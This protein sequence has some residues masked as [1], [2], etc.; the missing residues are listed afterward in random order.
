MNTSLKL[1]TLGVLAY[2][3]M[4]TQKAGAQGLPPA[5]GLP[6]SGSILQSNPIISAPTDP[7]TE[8]A[9]PKIDGTRPAATSG[10]ADTADEERV[11]V[12]RIVVDG[13]PP[14]LETAIKAI[15]VP[16]QD[17]Q[18][19]LNDLRA[20]A[21]QVTQVLLD[22]GESLSYAYVPQQD[23]VDDVVRLAILRGHVESI[24]L[25]HNNSLVRD[26]VV[27][28]FLK[29]GLTQSGEL[30]VAQGQLDI[31]S[32]LPGIGGITPVLAAGDTPGG[33]KLT[34]NVDPTRRFE[35]AMVFDNA[36]S[37]S[38]GRNRVGA[39]AT[40]NSPL[41]IGDRL[42]VV[43]YGAPDFL[44][45]NHDSDGGFT[46]IGRASYDLPVNAR[47]ARAGFSF[48]R[49]N[50]NYGGGLRYGDGTPI[51][52]GLATVY[53]LYGSSPLLRTESSTLD[54]N[55]NLDYKRMSDWL[56]DLTNNRS[57]PVLGLQLNGTKRG[58]VFGLPNA[59]QYSAGASFGHL[60]RDAVL[61]D[62][63]TEGNFVKTTQSAR[64]T[65]G[66]VRG[67]YLDVTFDAQQS[68]RNLD[69]SEKMVLGGPGAVRAYSNDAASADSGYVA[70]TTLNVAVPKVN[71]VTLQA[72]YDRAQGA[73]SKFGGSKQNINISGAGV[74]VN[75]DVGK[76]VSANLSYAMRIG[77]DR[78][79]GSQ[80]KSMVW[81]SSVVRF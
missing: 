57:A 71:G 37:T 70:T 38:T 60:S 48:T 54:I 69:G 42:Q 22:N 50:Y 12:A 32:D 55:A 25:G 77:N 43:A 27:N 52:V 19:S 76:H 3:A 61:G 58:S 81:A 46:V 28:R 75:V 73:T 67:V 47:G 65:Q 30:K 68:S 66:L 63:L 24:T 72:F 40:V 78:A 80:H 79:L 35:G 10:G 4:G 5:Q 13:A 6:S 49:V 44:Q 31:L 20:V 64:L 59:I 7:R 34:V 11:H 23:I 39:Q 17:R 15:V 18:M 53:S 2:S 33:T 16:Y 29:R 36:G 9:A 1:I 62:P 56:V 51:G 21:V 45:G 26:S 41:G 8:G 14:E 74:G